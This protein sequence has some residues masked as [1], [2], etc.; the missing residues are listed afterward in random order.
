[1]KTIFMLPDKNETFLNRQQTILEHLFPNNTAK[2][3]T[4]FMAFLTDTTTDAIVRSGF[5]DL[6]FKCLFYYKLAKI[7]K[8]DFPSTTLSQK[9]AIELLFNPGLEEELLQFLKKDSL[10]KIIEF[11]QINS[12]K[13]NSGA[14]SLDIQ[15][16]L[17]LD[18]LMRALFK[19]TE[20]Y[21]KNHLTKKHNVIN[22]VPS[23]QLSTYLTKLK[24]K[25]NDVKM[26]ETKKIILHENAVLG[27]SGIFPCLAI[28][29]I[30]EKPDE[31]P[32]VILTHQSHDYESHIER[33][34][35]KYDAFEYSICFYLIG[36]FP[37][38]FDETLKIIYS[39]KY[40][41]KDVYLGIENLLCLDCVCYRENNTIFIGSKF[42]TMDEDIQNDIKNENNLSGDNADKSSFNL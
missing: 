31:Q 42:Y 39:D 41:I 29:A 22:A 17:N 4:H 24:R 3:L 16:Q 13:I 11:F 36:S 12:E 7:I 35:Q 32:I 6:Y 10:H 5:H 30:L 25:E 8:K 14:L 9:Y 19:Y 34:Y 38:S 21:G 2:K 40:P 1:M 26:E 28:V 23:A 33:I 27:T 20:W 37:S 15:P 18:R